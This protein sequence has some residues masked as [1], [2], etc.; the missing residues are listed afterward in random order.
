M[1]RF[2]SLVFVAGVVFAS[3]TQERITSS[4]ATL[5][6]TSRQERQ[7]GQQLETIAKAIS[8]ERKALDSLGK[9]IGALQEQIKTLQ[10]ETKGAAAELD[11]L[12][13]QNAQLE[14]TKQEL[15]QRMI[16]IVAE[17]FSFYLVTDQGY[18]ESME[19]IMADAV[20]EKMDEIIQK[21]FKEMHAQYTQTNE[22]IR[23]RNRSIARV[24]ESLRGLRTKESSL[25]AAREKQRQSLVALERQN[26]AYRQQLNQIYAQKKELEE[27]LERLKI[28]Q[29]EEVEKKAR[30]EAAA[31]AARATAAQT[32][33]DAQQVTVRQ[34]GSSYQ[35]SRVKRYTGQKTIA[36]LDDFEVKQ[37]FG[38]Y[39]DPIYNIRIFNES[40]VLRSK[41]PAAQVKNVLGGKVVYAGVT[42]MLNHVVIVE[43]S[44][45]IHTIYAQMTQIAPTIK[46]GARIKQGYVIGRVDHDLTFEVTQQNYH[47][48]PLELI[49]LR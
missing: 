37:A 38:N 21:D 36:P 8:D 19:S 32:P 2:F 40:V 45:G 5:A 14:R 3:S 43:N 44:N 4:S 25:L 47:I 28:V 35:N 48:N 6:A 9:E 15:E 33:S 30:E 46:V 27:T 22:E 34:I 29:R 18:H 23:N 26:N 11:A 39:V 31:A 7:I 17:Q 42:N 12:T 13:R 20:L 16:R 10:E 49:T 41:T 24:N 1:M